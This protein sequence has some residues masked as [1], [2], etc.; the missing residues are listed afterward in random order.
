MNSRNLVD[1]DM[2][3]QTKAK[4]AISFAEKKLLHLIHHV[5]IFQFF[6]KK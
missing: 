6:Y 3:N 1:F 2:V 5:C 4:Y